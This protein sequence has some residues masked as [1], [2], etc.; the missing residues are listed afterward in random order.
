MECAPSTGTNNPGAQCSSTSLS[1][2]LVSHQTVLTSSPEKA[3]R[4][5]CS[6]P[7]ALPLPQ[8]GRRHPYVHCIY[9]ALWLNIDGIALA[10]RR[11]M[12]N[13]VWSAHTVPSVWLPFPHQSPG[14][15][16]LIALIQSWA[17]AGQVMGVQL[18]FLH[19]VGCSSRDSGKW[20]KW[21]KAL[22]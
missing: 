7:P 21:R 15:P 17:S 11:V 20:K 18:S 8:S 2:S 16:G 19:F 22:L 9:L 6:P 5:T 10:L 4:N 12:A 3:P 14:L 1:S 13:R